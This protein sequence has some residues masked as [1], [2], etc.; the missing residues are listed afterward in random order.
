MAFFLCL[1]PEDLIVAVGV[2][3]RVDV[4]QVNT[5]IGEF[6]QLVEVVAAV[7]YPRIDQC[8]GLT[9]HRGFLGTGCRFLCHRPLVYPKPLNLQGDIT[10]A[11][12]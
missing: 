8:R 2:K 10:I 12:I 4:N 9:S 5:T 7:D 6:F 1:A 11:F 3:R